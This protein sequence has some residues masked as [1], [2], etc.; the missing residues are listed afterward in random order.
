MVYKVNPALDVSPD[1]PLSFQPLHSDF[2][3]KSDELGQRIYTR[4]VNHESFVIISGTFDRT[5]KITDDEKF[6]L[7]RVLK[8]FEKA[9]SK[10]NAKAINNL[11]D[12]LRDLTI[13]EIVQV[14]L[15]IKDQL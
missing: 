2:A 15:K 8:D 14:L 1:R 3:L 12:K 11:A 4:L 9:W 5:P 13:H 7:D 6:K 10:A